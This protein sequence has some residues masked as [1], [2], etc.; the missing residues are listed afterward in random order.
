MAKVKTRFVCQACG[1]ESPRWLGKCPECEAWNTLVEEVDTPVAGPGPLPLTG[2]VPAPLRLGEVAVKEEPRLQ[3]GFSEFDR[4]LGGGLVP[5]SLVLL[6]GDPGIGKSTLLLQVAYALAAKGRRVLYV[7]GEESAQ[8]VFLRTSRLGMQ[9][10]EHFHLLAE[11]NLDNVVALLQEMRPDFAVVD[12]I[13]AIYSPNLSSAPGS[14]AQIR[15]GTNLLLP[16]AKQTGVALGLVGHVNKEGNLAGPRV[17]EHMVDTVLY[18]EGERFRSHRLLRS[19]KNRFGATHEVGVFEMGHA[20]LQEVTNPSALFLA[21][22]EAEATGSVVTATMEGTR[23]LLVEI[24]ALAYPSPL[25]SPRRAATGGEYNRLVQILAVLEKRVGLPLSKHDVWLNVVGG[26]EVEEPGADLAIA[27]AVI[28]SMRDLPLP[29][30]TL[31]L[32]E[33]GLGGEVRGISQLEVR[34]HEAAKLGF[35]R[36]IVPKRNLPMTRPIKGLEVIGVER[37]LEALV[38]LRNPSHSQPVSSGARVDT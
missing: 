14:V 27:L 8:Q 30:R 13:Q 33:V 9:D 24:Q 18:F 32:G 11:N 12:S 22:Y 2:K 7:T 25:S 21:E 20:G 26:V 31:V 28:S 38:D 17:L 4:V 29:G 34:L 6:G 15:H 35:E 16:V 23:P 5:G 1:A 3:S 36:A 19:V 10:T 37:V